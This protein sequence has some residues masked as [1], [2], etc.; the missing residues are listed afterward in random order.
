M[1]TK[2]DVLRIK[3]TAIPDTESGYGFFY[4]VSDT[5][6][7][8]S[9]TGVVKELGLAA[10]PGGGIS[11]TVTAINASISSNEHVHVTASGKTITL[12]A[13]PTVN[14]TVY[15]SV[16]DFV[17]TVVGRNGEDIMGLAEDLTLD[18]SNI[19]TGLRYVS[20]SRGWQIV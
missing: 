17:D 19:T 2:I 1:T 3:E 8:K 15:I 10:T 13:T 4:T 7:F 12:P 14:D 16:E 5:P 18:K 11:V 20:A 9:G 6:Y